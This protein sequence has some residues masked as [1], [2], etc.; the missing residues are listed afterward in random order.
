MAPCLVRGRAISGLTASPTRPAPA[1]TRSAITLF[2]AEGDID[3]VVPL[4]YV[5]GSPLLDTAT[6][7]GQTLGSLGVTPGTYVWTWGTGADADSFTLIATVAEPSTWAMMLL[8]FAGLGFVGY[9][10][11]RVALPAA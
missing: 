11:V 6:Y 4:G 1:A 3:I 9:R 10:R 7:A 8:G 5:S 2:P